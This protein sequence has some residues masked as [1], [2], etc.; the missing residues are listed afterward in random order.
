MIIGIG[1][2]VILIE[3]F[4]MLRV[5]T[6][7]LYSAN[8]FSFIIRILFIKIK[9]PMKKKNETKKEKKPS[10]EYIKKLGG[11]LPKFNEIT[12]L[13]K[14]ALGKLIRGIRIHELNADIVIAGEDPFKTA[15]MYGGAA[16]AFGALFP[17]LENNFNIIKKNI[18]VDLDFTTRES[19]VYFMSKQSIAIWRVLAII[20]SL[21][22]HFYV[23]SKKI[24]A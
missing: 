12:R 6:T 16:I 22:Y 19:T 18:K 1:I 13:A 21:A 14:D 7:L 4:F 20:I 23:S 3:L 2:A 15:M 5:K 17:I 11:S 10:P 9:L 24:K 8:G